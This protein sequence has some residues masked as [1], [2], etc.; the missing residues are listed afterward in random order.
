MVNNVLP[1]V[2]A[3]FQSSCRQQNRS[4]FG[5]YSRIT[6]VEPTIENIKTNLPLVVDIGVIDLREKASLRRLQRIM[7]WEN[8]L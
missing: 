8:E 7:L 6:G 1:I 4:E 3:P 2:R 5:Y